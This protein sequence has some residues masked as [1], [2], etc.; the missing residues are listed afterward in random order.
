MYAILKL[1]KKWAILAQLLT[2]LL[3]IGTQTDV[4]GQQ[5]SFGKHTHLKKALKAIKDGR[6]SLR[7]VITLSKGALNK[8]LPK[9]L[10][11]KS[12]ET[13]KNS[14]PSVIAAASKKQVKFIDASQMGSDAFARHYALM[15]AIAIVK[16]RIELQQN[17]EKLTDAGITPLDDLEKLQQQKAFLEKRVPESKQ[18]AAEFKFNLARQLLA[19]SA[20]GDK[21]KGRRSYY[22]VQHCLNLVSDFPQAKELQQEALKKGTILVSIKLMASGNTYSRMAKSALR[23]N[24][25]ALK[26]KYENMR[27]I[28]FVEPDDQTADIALIIDIF[29]VRLEYQRHTPL[30]RNESRNIK[31]KDGSKRAVSCSFTEHTKTFSAIMQA[32]INVIDHTNSGRFQTEIVKEGV[33]SKQLTWLTGVQGDERAMPYSM[34]IHRGKGEP[35]SPSKDTGIR[36]AA[37]QFSSRHMTPLFNQLMEVVRQY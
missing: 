28:D 32:K 4:H 26:A 8:K 14:Y 18:L 25:I 30:K 19:E 22:E 16:Q 24:I 21:K 9:R 7:S 3:F 12:N 1:L 37:N 5:V 6:D 11:K 20:S 27:F 23:N 34:R 13:L 10:K 2:L 29:S 36:L 15:R 31:M 17:L 33:F 35:K